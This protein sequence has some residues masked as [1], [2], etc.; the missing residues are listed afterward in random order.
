M[1]GKGSGPK[2][3][4]HLWKKGQ[5]GNPQGAR[6]HDPVARAIKNLTKAELVEVGNLVI[7]NDIVELRKLVKSKDASVLKVWIANVCLRGIERGDVAA[8]DV[9]LNRLIGRVKEDIAFTTN[10]PQV[11]INLPSNGREVKD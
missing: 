7:K 5:S 8:L 3:K 6:L 1:G 11:T 2:D 10:L 4:R 9:L